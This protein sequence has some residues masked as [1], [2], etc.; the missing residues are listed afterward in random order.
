M[1]GINDSTLVHGVLDL[2]EKRL[3]KDVGGQDGSPSVIL[4]REHPDD[5]WVL[6]RVKMI[7]PS[8]F[9]TDIKL[10]M[11][12]TE[13]EIDNALIKNIE[14]EDTSDL[15]SVIDV[16]DPSFEVLDDFNLLPHD[17]QG[18]NYVP[19]LLEFG[20][21]GGYLIQPSIPLDVDRDH[22]DFEYYKKWRLKNVL[23][24]Q[25]DSGGVLL[26]SEYLHLVYDL[27]SRLTAVVVERI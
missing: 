7:Y 10:N 25:R 8:G 19:A 16:G 12:M 5:E 24:E 20:T 26:Q 18:S 2:I 27:K 13:E 17:E 9:Q 15:P 21:H 3:K 4:Y 1:P 23:V 11:G 14:S 6:T 22:H